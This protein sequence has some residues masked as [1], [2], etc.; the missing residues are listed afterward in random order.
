M[1]S[2][3]DSNSNSSRFFAHLKQMPTEI[4]GRIWAD[5]FR[6]AAEEHADRFID[7]HDELSDYRLSVVIGKRIKLT[8][9][10]ANKYYSMI[11]IEDLW[12]NMY[13]YKYALEA[14]V[15]CDCLRILETY[16]ERLI[17]QPTVRFGDIIVELMD[18]Y[19][20]S[21]KKLLYYLDRIPGARDYA[22][23]IA[24]Y[25]R[26]WRTQIEWL[27]YNDWN[28]AYINANGTSMNGRGVSGRGPDGLD[29]G[30]NLGTSVTDV[31]AVDSD[32]SESDSSSSSSFNERAEGSDSEEET[33]F[34]TGTG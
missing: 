21:G 12:F 1:A 13:I 19:K 3:C 27:G 28:T 30:T 16:K 14:Q 23:D 9:C 8:L 11:D 34:G 6:L 17:N 20:D 10:R 24:A 5:Y 15:K 31:I 18:E 4:Q 29:S 26:R 2:R 33:W 32:D 25:N 22:E 7:I